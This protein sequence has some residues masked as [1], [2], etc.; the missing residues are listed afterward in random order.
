MRREIS[1]LHVVNM[2][3]LT[4]AE[5]V[6]Q[7]QESARRSLAHDSETRATKARR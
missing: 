1:D 3:S 4:T 2:R 7:L 6:Q 5:F